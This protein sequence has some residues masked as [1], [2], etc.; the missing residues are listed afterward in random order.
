MAY[1]MHR[2]KVVRLQGRKASMAKDKSE[3]EACTQGFKHKER[4]RRYKEQ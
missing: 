4:N 2:E 1:L 3:R